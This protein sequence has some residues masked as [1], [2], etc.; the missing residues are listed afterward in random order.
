MTGF[1]GQSG[2]VTGGGDGIGRAIALELG[3]QGV[4]VSVLDVNEAAAAETADAIISAGGSAVSFHA[5]I[6]DETSVRAA[7]NATVDAHGGLDLAVNN[8]AIPS[9]GQELT[10]MTAASWQR[11]IAVN[12]TGTF[13]SMKHEILHLQQAGGGAIVNIASNGGL[14]AIGHAPAYVA[15]KHG[16]VGLTK[17]AAIDYAPAGVR[18]NAVAPALTRTAMFD[19]V[20]EGTDM[21]AQQEAITPLGRLAMPDEIA[22]AAVWLCS[23][24]SSY[25]TGIT[26]SVDGGRRA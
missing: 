19:E 16:V 24:E 15:S 21:V 6:S 17:A 2:L 1:S 11:V 13:Y 10:T 20:A 8:A 9:T 18:V 3:R 12:L 7:V 23:K 26:L 22:H 4:A 14:Y 25:V 5:D